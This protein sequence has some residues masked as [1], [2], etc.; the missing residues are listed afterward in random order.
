MGPESYNPGISRLV[1]LWVQT[2]REEGRVLMMYPLVDVMQSLL[3]GEKTLLRCG[4]GG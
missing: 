4:A 3:K 2:M 1:C